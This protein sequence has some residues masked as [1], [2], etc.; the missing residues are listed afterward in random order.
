MF[1][2][3]ALLIHYYLQNL[4]SLKEF[5]FNVAAFITKKSNN[6]LSIN[7]QRVEQL[8]RKLIRFSAGEIC[9]K[10]IW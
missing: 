4:I 10:V 8:I 6:D 9:C 5:I 1:G 2:H 3:V 7:L